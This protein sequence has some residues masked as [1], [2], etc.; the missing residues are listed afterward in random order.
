MLHQETSHFDSSS[1]LNTLDAKIAER[2]LLLHPFYQA[3][4]VGE[5]SREAL[6]DYARQYYQ[7]VAAFPTYLSGVHAQ[8]D[9]LETRRQVLE[10]L[11]DEEA[12][13]PN[14]PELWVHFAEGLGVSEQ[15]VKNT[16]LW[17]E[18]RFLIDTFREVC[19]EHG[20]AAGLSALYAYESQIPEVAVSKKN[21]LRKN[22]GIDD[23]KTVAYFDVH[24][25]ADKEH[26]AVERQLLTK[27]VNAGNESCALEAAD[28]V[29]DALWGI[30]DGVCR[31]HDIG[32]MCYSKN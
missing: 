8:T 18:T 14:H 27:H 31:R 7:H 6:Q 32:Q 11:I 22:Y 5:L 12:G 29:L 23:A 10:N 21:G 9:D 30:L 17:P 24:E 13:K 19:R 16:V 20:T 2:S 28:Q 26:A 4:T 15:D 25:E 3:W 1:F